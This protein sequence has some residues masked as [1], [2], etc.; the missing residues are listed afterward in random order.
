MEHGLCFLLPWELR[1]RINGYEY[2]TLSLNFC[3]IFLGEEWNKMGEWH[4]LTYVRWII[5]PYLK[6]VTPETVQVNARYL[7]SCKK[8]ELHP[9]REIVGIRKLVENERATDTVEG[10]RSWRREET[11]TTKSYFINWSNLRYG[12]T[13]LLEGCTGL[14]K[15]KLKSCQT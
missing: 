13:T 5:S 11:E 4:R 6:Q 2:M 12:K 14:Q 7:P 9:P 15:E 3:L 8:D 10:D 1:M